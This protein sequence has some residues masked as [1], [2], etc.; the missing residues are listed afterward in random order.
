M[1]FVELWKTILVVGLFFNVI[2]GIYFE[3]LHMTSI[4]IVEVHIKVL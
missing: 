3:T 1:I 2:K 4:K